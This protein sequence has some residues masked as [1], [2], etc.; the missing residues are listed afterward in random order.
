MDRP[1]KIPG[2]LGAAGANKICKRGSGSR[3]EGRAQVIFVLRLRPEPG[4]DAIRA[5]RWTLKALLRR[6]GL[7]CLSIEE[8]ASR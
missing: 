4:V 6:H 7:R 8:E 5:L 2:A 1:N 3:S